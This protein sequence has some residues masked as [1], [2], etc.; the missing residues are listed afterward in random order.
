MPGKNDKL[1]RVKILLEALKRFRQAGYRKAHI[2]DIASAAGISVKTLHSYFPSKKDIFAALFEEERQNV[3]KNVDTVFNGV[4][5]SKKTEVI[6]A[7]KELAGIILNI[8]LLDMIYYYGDFPVIYCVHEGGEENGGMMS[9]HSSLLESFIKKC[10]KSGTVRK[11]N[12]IELA[13]TFRTL[14]YLM[15]IESS[16]LKRM[17][18]VEKNLLNIFI[19]GICK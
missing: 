6:N 13:D 15:L 16:Y 4:N 14:I 9:G 11:G 7:F 12:A 5:C 2:K 19:D 17:P 1:T 3:R 8:P 10:R 18:E